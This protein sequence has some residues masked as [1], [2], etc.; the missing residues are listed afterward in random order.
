MVC[1]PGT[2]NSPMEGSFRQWVKWVASTTCGYMV[3]YRR[4]PTSDA[5]PSHG[6]FL[7]F[8]VVQKEEI[9]LQIVN[10]K[11]ILLGT[12]FCT[13]TP[14]RGCAG[15]IYKLL[16]IDCNGAPG[17]QVYLNKNWHHSVLVLTEQ[18]ESKSMLS[19]RGHSNSRPVPVLT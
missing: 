4:V 14:R 10:M 7:Y 17:T 3:A 5:Y 9:T 19:Q 8:P 11:S 15:A 6:P 12:H 18:V 2:S 16:I 13:D 1:T